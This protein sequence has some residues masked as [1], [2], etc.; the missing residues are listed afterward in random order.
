[1][2][3]EKIVQGNTVLE[4]LREFTAQLSKGTSAWLTFP[5]MPVL[6]GSCKCE[7]SKLVLEMAM[8]S[9]SSLIHGGGDATFAGLAPHVWAV[10]GLVPRGALPGVGDPNL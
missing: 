4:N 3:N 10:A 9:R 1:M 2:D 5:F 6:S 8:N 7:H